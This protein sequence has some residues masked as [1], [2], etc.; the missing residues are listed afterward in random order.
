MCVYAR[1][2]RPRVATDTLPLISSVAQKIDHIKKLPDH[3]RARDTLEECARHVNPLL[4]ARGWRVNKLYEICC[5][6][7]GG[8]NLGVGGFCCPAGDGLTSLRIALRLR[9]PK[10][11]ELHDFDHAMRVLIHEVRRAHRR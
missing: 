2:V 11:H 8:K 10:S 9:H 4:K 1:D 7:A 3:Q 6:T 5:C